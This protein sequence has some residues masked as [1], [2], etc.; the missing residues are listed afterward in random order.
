M[1][2]EADMQGFQR[3]RG[4]R[5]WTALWAMVLACGLVVGLSACATADRPSLQGQLAGKSVTVVTAV[6]ASLNLS[7]RGTTVFNNEHGRAAVPEWQLRERV[8]DRTAELL[9]V[10]GRYLAVDTASISSVRREDAL[11]ELQLKTD[12]VLLITPARAADT[13]F[14]TNVGFNGLGIA[15]RSALQLMPQS[16]VHVALKADLLD[17]RIVGRVVAE[18]TA[19]SAQRIPAPALLAGPRLNADLTPAAREA[20]QLQVDAAVQSLVTQLGLN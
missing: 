6:D 17:N 5:G 11:K 16:A 1:N 18:A 8:Q 12:F 20:M 19:N 7:W 2:Q 14:D 9:R 15:Q 10:S 4:A 3:Q 13:L